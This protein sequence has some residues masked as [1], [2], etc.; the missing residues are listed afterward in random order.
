MLAAGFLTS[1]TGSP[2]VVT[3]APVTSS[4]SVAPAPRT[5]TLAA[6]GD[7]LIHPALTDQAVADGSGSRNYVPLL[8]GIRRAVD[9]DLS[10]CHMEVPLGKP[11][12]PFFGYPAFLAPPEVARGL[13]DI[14]YDSC[15]TASNH[16]LD[17]GPSAIQTTLDAMDAVGLK[18]TGSFR[19]PEEAAAPL[20]LDAGGVKV[21]QL[22]FTYGFN[23]IPLPQPWM[24]NQINVAKILADARAARA[25]GA[26]VVVLSVQWGNEYQHEATAEQKSLAR[27]LL[28]D[29]ALDLIIGTHVHVVQPF[30][31]IGGKW[32][33]YGLGN[34][35]A[36][37]SEPRGVTEEGV[38]ARFTF[39]QDASGWKVTKAEY[40][41]TLV[42]LGPPIRL[43]DLT[44]V[45]E[46]PRRAEAI[47]RTEDVLFSMGAMSAGLTR[48]RP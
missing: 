22:S 40:V 5:F 31:N 24:A 13:K 8:E 4:S 42:E 16:T 26:E 12:G 28:A 11:E 27:Q 29:P 1:C 9:A 15:S 46:T 35:V 14:G 37:H 18:H 34:E 6:G 23:G 20:L 44:R 47:K 33:T 43:V 10:I 45:G 30:E 48:A 17:R 41:P 39:T 36:R 2:V 19:T 21:A 3:S 25:A 38:I 32:V 7:I